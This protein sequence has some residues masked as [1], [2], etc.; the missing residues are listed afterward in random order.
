MTKINMA[1]AGFKLKGLR[2]KM[3]YSLAYTADAL[4]ITTSYLSSIENGKKCPSKKI[5]SK[6]SSLFNVSIDE[7][8]E[9][10]QLI[11]EVR[12]I[13]DSAEISEMIQIFEV[14]L[15]EKRHNNNS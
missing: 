11:D 10:S 5:L 14:L 8:N 3:Q 4:D 12:E 15:R 6:A 13:T 2:I 9:P 1:F 7:F